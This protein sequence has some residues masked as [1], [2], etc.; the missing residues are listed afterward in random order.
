M[1]QDILK[2]TE[3]LWTGLSIKAYNLTQKAESF[4][5]I[6]FLLTVSMLY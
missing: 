4:K 2:R 3:P 1:R 5:S 6:H